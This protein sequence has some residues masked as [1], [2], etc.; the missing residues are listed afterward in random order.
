MDLEQATKTL[1]GSDYAMDSRTSTTFPIKHMSWDTWDPLLIMPVRNPKPVDDLTTFFEAVHEWRFIIQPQER[2]GTAWRNFGP[3]FPRASEVAN[4]IKTFYVPMMKFIVETLKKETKSSDPF[5]VRIQQVCNSL[6]SNKPS[7]IPLRIHFNYISRHFDKSTVK[8]EEIFNIPILQ[9]F[10]DW[11]LR[12]IEY[13]DDDVLSI[14]M[15]KFNLR[16]FDMLRQVSRRFANWTNLQKQKIE[17]MQD[18]TVDTHCLGKFYE[19]TPFRAHLIKCIRDK[20][21]KLVLPTQSVD[22]PIYKEQSEYLKIVIPLMTHIDFHPP[23]HSPRQTYDRTKI[24][25][26]FDL[27]FADSR[28]YF[29]KSVSFK[30]SINHDLVLDLIQSFPL[31]NQLKRIDIVEEMPSEITL[32]HPLFQI[33]PNLQLVNFYKSMTHL[34]RDSTSPI[35]TRNN[36]LPRV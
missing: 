8:D 34:L 12:T 13:L 23:S 7:N 10:V 9:D 24:Q 25:T 36:R 17:D 20:R 33:C 5:D 11:N 35:D 4:E 26:M 30:A 22:C 14:L 21:M 32:P 31:K 3:Q 6:D 1:A 28:D 15:S 29:L 16:T 27:L 19:S 2:Y 18:F